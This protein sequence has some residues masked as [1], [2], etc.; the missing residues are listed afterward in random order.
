MKFFNACST[1]DEVRKLY[2]N[3]AK[4][5]HPDAGGS[6]AVMQEINNEYAFASAKLLK[7]ENLTDVQIEEE[8]RFSK[9]YQEVIEKIGNLPEIIIELVGRWIWVSGNTEDV[10][11]QLKAAGLWWAPKKKMWYYRSEDFKVRHGGKKSMEEIRTTY[12]TQI[13]NPHFHKKI[14]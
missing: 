12:G 8:I 10:K 14:Q 3:L 9:E 6:T 7:G 13:V 11:T 2:R 5:N 1:I 4:E